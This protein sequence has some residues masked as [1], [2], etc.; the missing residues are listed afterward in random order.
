MDKVIIV[1][2]GDCGVCSYLVKSTF[3]L[4]KLS[5]KQNLFYTPL[6]SELGLYFCEKIK[7]NNKLIE[8]DTMIFYQYG[9]IYT[10]SSAL[11]RCYSYSSGL[12]FLKLLLF[13]PIQIRDFFYQ[14][15][16]KNRNWLSK[17]FNLESEVTCN[18]NEKS[19]ISLKIINNIS[20]I[21]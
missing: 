10:N 12:S 7:N 8:K 11:I 16:A 21:K 3:W 4:S 13:I 20:E 9:N 15:I 5:N 14:L 6:S 2:D 19:A 18:L 1:Y 17:L